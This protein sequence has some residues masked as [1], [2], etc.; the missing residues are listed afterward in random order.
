MNQS[1]LSIIINK[2]LAEVFEFVINPN[3]TPLWFDSIVKE[4]ADLPIAMG[5]KYVN[6][7]AAGQKG[8]YLVSKFEPDAIFQLDSVDSGYKVRYTLKA[9]S[10]NETELEY[11]EW[12]DFG[13]LEAPCAINVL[14]GLKNVLE[15]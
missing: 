11:L 8:E 12:V 14:Q 4:V 13:D 7:N 10:K 9:I 3:N 1:K 5:T 15:G 2:S 6:F